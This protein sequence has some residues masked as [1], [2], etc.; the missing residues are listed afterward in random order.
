MYK[1]HDETDTYTET[2]NFYARYVKGAF[3]NNNNVDL[4]LYVTRYISVS[5]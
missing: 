1:L 5:M 2:L 3:L 4:M